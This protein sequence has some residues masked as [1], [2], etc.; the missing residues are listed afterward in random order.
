MS[1]ERNG[2][3]RLV[4]WILGALLALAGILSGIAHTSI[5]KQLDSIEGRINRIESVFLKR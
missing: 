1:D 4:Y 5:M 3:N 2:N